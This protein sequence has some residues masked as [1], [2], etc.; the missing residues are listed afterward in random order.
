MIPSSTSEGPFGQKTVLGWGI[1][2]TINKITEVDSFGVSHHELS[3][4][5]FRCDKQRLRSRIILRSRVKEV[6]PEDVLSVLQSDFYESTA[7][8]PDRI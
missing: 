2:G 7:S 5:L 1:V 6:Y 8:F 4:G 3:H